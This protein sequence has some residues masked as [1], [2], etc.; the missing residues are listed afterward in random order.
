M[1]IQI[2]TSH[3][4]ERFV[5]RISGTLGFSDNAGF[6]ALIDQINASGTRHC[7]FELADLKSVDSAG[8]GM[9]VIAH[10]AAK[11]NGWTL[12]LTQ[13]AGQVKQLLALARFDKLM[14]IAP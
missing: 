13:P 10:E 6:R 11:K 9:F 7:A 3:H 12:T 1:P 4:G 14:A 2:E 5:A 8:L